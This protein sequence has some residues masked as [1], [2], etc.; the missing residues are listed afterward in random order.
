M[1]MDTI[2]PAKII[3]LHI[4]DAPWMTSHLKHLIKCRQKAL[5]VTVQHSSN[6]PVAKLIERGNM[7]K[8]TSIK[9]K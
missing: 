3:K 2:M 5:K 6:S 1:D 9:Q 4:N 8:L 7:P